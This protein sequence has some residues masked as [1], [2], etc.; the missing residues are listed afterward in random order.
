VPPFLIGC[1]VAVVLLCLLL[2]G[3]RAAIRWFFLK[4]KS[5]S[6]LAEFERFRTVPVSFPSEWVKPKAPAPELS[7]AIARTTQEWEKISKPLADL[8]SQVEV[9]R[10]AKSPGSSSDINTSIAQIATLS[11]SALVAT[12]ETVHRPDYE[13]ILGSNFLSVQT[14]AKAAGARASTEANLQHWDAACQSALLPFYM[15]RREPASNLVTHLVAVAIQ[16][17][18]SRSLGEVASLCPESQPLQQALSELNA[19]HDSIVLNVLDRA[20]L[21]DILSALRAYEAE[22]LPVSLEPGKPVQFYQNQVSRYRRRFLEA[23]LAKIP[24]G[25]ARDEIERELSR[26]PLP[27]AELLY[28]MALPEFVYL[29]EA[30]NFV[31][32][33]TRE[34]VSAARIDLVRLYL[35]QRIEQLRGASVTSSPK[36]LAA[37][38]LPT[39]PLD[40]FTGKSWLRGVTYLW[41]ESRQQFY[42]VGPNYQDDGLATEYE[43]TNGTISSGD[44]PTPGAGAKATRP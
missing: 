29:M 23:Q 20:D 30:P 19:L 33:Q 10:R 41:S 43:P 18:G 39:E 40:P 14:L 17:L 7:A 12:S 1:A 21:V 4:N 13:L 44:I 31:E 28:R 26:T 11:A 24:L 37:K 8:Q 27:A 34:R 15:S 3:G 22:G 25:A 5:P 6:E 35:A 16:S 2:L 9:A 38:Y 42:S 32:A 36:V